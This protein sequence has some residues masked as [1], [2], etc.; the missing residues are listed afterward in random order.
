[1]KEPLVKEDLFYLSDEDSTSPK[2]SIH[3]GDFDFDTTV[4]TL[5]HIFSKSILRKKLANILA[6]FYISPILIIL[7]S[8]I[9]GL[10]FFSLPLFL[11]YF[12][13][14]DNFINNFIAML[15]IT[16]ILCVLQIV[17]RIFDDVKNKV[18]VMSKWERKNVITTSGLIL[19]LI[20]IIVGAFK[21]K[22][23]FED[24]LIYNKEKKLIIIYEP[25]NNEDND[26]NIFINDF[27]IKSIVNCFL[28]NINK[29]KNE[30][31]KV[32]NYISD[33]SII[34]KL[35][36]DLKICSIPILIYS[37]NKL[38]QS[39]IIQIKYTIPKIIIFSSFCGLCILMIIKNILYKEKEEDLL[40]SILQMILI[41][42]ITGGYL[43]W[44][45]SNM[46]RR[47]K[48][49]KDKN[50]AIDRY[51]LSQLILIF[52]FDFIN[53]IAVSGMF[54]S[55]LLNFVNF[56]NKEETFRDLKLAT[57]VLKIGFMVFTLSN[58]FYYGHYFLSLIFRPIALQHAP[59]KLKENYVR[60]TKNL[61]S[62]IFI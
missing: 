42:L 5:K 4:E 20:L 3:S 15:M 51:E 21:L 31:V 39:I 50:F 34:T 33:Y 28:L 13:V 57:L 38:I 19:T 25:E 10:I 41:T 58:S 47:F 62:Y 18:G 27:F 61:S 9:T 44:C 22:D 49:P 6:A 55:I 14:F 52:I 30:E 32:T 40:L 35:I 12:R 17:I 23:L 59:I 46:W 16:L 48:K 43:S 53:I 45:F 56:I 26:D 2:N 37:F 29:I 11:I 24:I 36:E 60:S 1:M 7:F 54:I 8:F